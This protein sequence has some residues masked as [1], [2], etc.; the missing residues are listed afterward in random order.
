MIKCPH[1]ESEE[2]INVKS[3]E[4]DGAHCTCNQCHK[5]FVYGEESSTK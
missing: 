1:C 3:Y 2:H 5:D 4:K